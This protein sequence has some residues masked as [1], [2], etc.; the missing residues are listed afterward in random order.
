MNRLERLDIRLCLLVMAILVALRIGT[1]DEGILFVACL[2]M[3]WS[4]FALGY[5]LV[6]GTAGI[7]SFGHAAFF[8]MG[9][10]GMTWAQMHGGLP[11]SLGLVAAGL[12]G[13]ACAWGVSLIGSRITGLFFSLLTLMMAELMS[14]LMLTRLRGLSGG[15]DG[16]P[17]VARPVWGEIDFFNNANFFWVV[18]AVFIAVVLACWVL[19]RSP[20]GQALQAVRQNPVRAEQLGFGVRRLRQAAMAISGGV[21]GI[22]GGLL[23]SLMMYTGP[24]M[25]GWKTSGDVLIMTL[26]GG[27]GTLLGPIVGVA[28]F[29]VLREVLAAYTDYWYGLVGLVFI[30]CT[31]FLPKGLAGTA[32]HWWSK[33]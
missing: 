14:V 23:A 32:L 24:Q 8:G 16:L 9:A 20:L 27:S 29:E 21:S 31:L 12:L 6:F 5:D 2:V 18:F 1:R 22:A 11:F 19:R 4:I 7:L 17:G 3:V 25:L 13:A 30:L 26:L 33:R 28:F 15:V 10:F